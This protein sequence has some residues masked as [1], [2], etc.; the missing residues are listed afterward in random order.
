[1]KGHTL[2]FVLGTPLREMMGT[3][4]GGGAIH[5]QDS[6]SAKVFIVLMLID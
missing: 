1:M 2:C 4:G 5:M 6:G 3:G